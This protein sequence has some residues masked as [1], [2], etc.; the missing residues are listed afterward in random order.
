MGFYVTLLEGPTPEDARAV[1][2][3]DDD[4]VVRAVLRALRSRLLAAS[5]VPRPRKR[6]SR[7]V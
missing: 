1:L 7:Q 4:R 5:T 2:V 6:N 3:T